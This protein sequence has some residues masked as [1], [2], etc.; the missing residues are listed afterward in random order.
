MMSGDGPVARNL[1]AQAGS[2]RTLVAVGDRRV[3]DM[4]AARADAVD[5]APAGSLDRALREDLAP[6]SSSDTRLGVELD[7]SCKRR[8]TAF[9][10]TEAEARSEEAKARAE[11]AK[12]RAAVALEEKQRANDERRIACINA[13]IQMDPGG[14]VTMAPADR[15]AI[16]DLMRTMVLGGNSADG[17]RGQPICIEA[18]LRSKG[19][20]DATTRRG[21]FGKIVVKVWQE[22]NPG[23]APPKKD[24]YAN[25]QRVPANA[26]WEKD[27]GIIEEAFAKWRPTED[28]PAAAPSG[29]LDRF[30]LR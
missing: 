28:V 22:K 9:E 2:L 17:E 16:T 12:A 1:F 26:Y 23:Q 19:I 10:L 30:L 20:K 8:R 21:S 11:E 4:A 25:G 13:W 3:A 29:G 5:A 24:V 14:V 15:V 7:A 27:R 18:F 6:G